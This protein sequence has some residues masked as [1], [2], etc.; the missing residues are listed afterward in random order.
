MPK[1]VFVL[2][3]DEHNRQVLE[4][5]PGAADCAFHQLLTFEEIYRDEIV[6]DQL[7]AQAQ[8]QLDSFD[9]PIDAIIG[10]WD[11]PIS[12]ML[13]LLRKRYGLP[14][15]RPEE[16]LMCEHKYWS[17]LV[18]QQVIEEYPAF[19]LVD[20][21]H[22]G[23]PPEGLR[24]PMWVKPVK[25]FASVLAIGV[26]DDEAFQDALST[27]RANMD[28]VATPFEALL[29]YVDLPAEI[30]EAGSRACLVEEAIIGRQV[31]VEGYRYEGKVVLYGV[32]DSVCYDNSPSFLRYQY[33][34]SLPEPVI[35]R[36]ED[37]SDRL[38]RAIGLERMTFNI[39]Y[40]WD[41]GTDAVALLEI[42]SRHSQSHAEL[43]AYVD[44][45]ANH[46]AML[47]LALGQ[48][49]R[50]PHREG[51]YAVAAKW[52]VRRFTDGVVRRIPTPEEIEAIQHIVPGTTIELT[53]HQGDRLSEL[54]R[55][56]NYS[57]QLASVYMGADDEAELT[58]KFEQV[59]AA[60]Q[61]EIDNVD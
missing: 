3:M 47:R 32:V 52:F 60:L 45:M 16:V 39:E 30:A 41:P 24:Y 2:G 51:P 1:N 44:G 56:D 49:P 18:Q 54:H 34:S 14:G 35:E 61:F 23:G 9:G 38:V 42:N 53:V 58:A 22:D 57:Y 27:I 17:R 25:S 40:F 20:P 29:K 12:T 10:F 4:D 11:F 31:T 21:D 7:L 43:F 19:G 59:V 13:P 55:Q 48:D 37:I 5:M 33:P 8:R 28:W 26:N 15:A 50:F 6:L 36:L 46:A